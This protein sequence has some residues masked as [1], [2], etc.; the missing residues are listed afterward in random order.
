MREVRLGIAGLGT[1]AQGV[2]S[3]LASN[4]KKISQRTGVELIVQRIAS[5]TPK[6]GVDLMGAE[7]TT[8][9]TSLLAND[10]D[11]VVELIGGE[12]AAKT[13][14]E[15]ALQSG[16]SVVTANKAIVAKYG[17]S[18]LATNGSV[19]NNNVA[20]KYEA[21]V[22]GAI[23]IIQSIEQGLVANDIQQVVGIING[24][25]NYILTAMQTEGASFADA[26]ERAQ[27]LGYA[28]ADPTFD[29]EGID[30]AHKLTILCGLAFDCLLDFDAVYVEGISAITAQDIQYAQELGY[31][32]KHVGIAK[33]NPYGIEARV[34]PALIPTGHL[35]ANVNDVAN[36]VLVQSDA[37]GQTLFSGPGAGS[38]ATASAVLADVLSLHNL[39]MSEPS[40]P[41]ESLQYLPIGDIQCAHYLRVPVVDEPGVFAEVANVLSRHNIS[42][43][44]VIQKEPS[45]SEE[46][47]AIVILTGKAQESDVAEA[48]NQL[49]TMPHSVGEIIRI[50]VES[51]GAS[52]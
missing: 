52:V 10:I 43:E 4:S 7:F 13:L 19:G 27:Q 37:A 3:I 26:L 28:E 15:E 25:C 9:L 44:A 38:L 29:V 46:V 20:L 11:V 51:L 14:I 23:P 30:A 35:L 32:I 41:R 48:V 16:K 24:T 50:R 8:D 39:P 18:L 6:P 17:N 22:A 40:A 36:A 42:I 21:A 2:L 12:D 5:R 45:S 34:H 33:R 1:V 49:A 47:V 31:Q